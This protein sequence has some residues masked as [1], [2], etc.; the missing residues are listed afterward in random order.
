[1]PLPDRVN[2]VDFIG[3]YL[4]EPVEFPN[5]TC[6]TRILTRRHAARST[7]GGWSNAG[8]WY[9]GTKRLHQGFSQQITPL[10]RRLV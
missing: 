8:W 10:G 9:C 4:E 1:V 3:G 6:P 7:S 2:E 5:A